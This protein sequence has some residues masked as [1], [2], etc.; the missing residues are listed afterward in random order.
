MQRNTNKL[1]FATLLL[2]TLLL[3]ACSNGKPNANE[4]SSTQANTKTMSTVFGNVDVPMEP[5][6]IVSV[7]LEDMLLSLDAPLVQASGT[8]GDYLYDRLQD[9]K[10]PTL[11]FSSTPNYEAI[12]AANPDLIIIIDGYVDQAGFEKLSQ[13]A[14]TLV[15]DRGDWKTSIVQI[16]KAINREEQAN[17]IIKAYDDKLSKARQTIAQSVGTN[18]TVTLVRLTDKEADV[19]FPKFPYGGVLY[20]DLGLKP[21]VTLM[22]FQKTAEEDWGATL[23]LEKLPE[24]KAD[25]LFVTAGYSA[26][27]EEEFQKTLETVKGVESLQVWK[28]IP[29]VKQNHTYKVSARHWMLNGPIADSMKIDDVVQA[30]TVTK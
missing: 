12:L 26:S 19:F 30:L 5:K 8:R 28:A 13:I 9:K 22:E 18:K 15:Y 25:Y 17:E 1:L 29:A 10:V 11:N 24:L 23:S 27:S 4:N 2:F 7:G 14:P 21:D 6:R 3:G 16:G 20:N